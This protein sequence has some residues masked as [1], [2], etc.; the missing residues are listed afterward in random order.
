[1]DMECVICGGTA[2]DTYKGEPNC[3]DKN[4]VDTMDDTQ[5]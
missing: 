3:Y 4:C 2:I 5:Q 1:M